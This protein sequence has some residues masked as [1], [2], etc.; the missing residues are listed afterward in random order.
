MNLPVHYKVRKFLTEWATTNF[1]RTLLHGIIVTWIAHW[2]LYYS[3][4]A[5]FSTETMTWHPPPLTATALYAGLTQKQHF[6]HC[7][8]CKHISTSTTSINLTQLTNHYTVLKCPSPQPYAARVHLL[9]DCIWQTSGHP[10]TAHALPIPSPTHT[11]LL[12][13]SIP[14]APVLY[15]G[16]FALTRR[17]TM[18][19]VRG[20][21][22]NLRC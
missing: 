21:W 20:G 10:L 22:T 15:S 7:C 18:Y 16:Y 6:L 11:H 12:I 14:G 8:L 9:H 2:E 1:L 3:S 17:S 4:L 19:L 13:T 5:I